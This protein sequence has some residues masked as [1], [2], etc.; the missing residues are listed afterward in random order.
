M[1]YKTRKSIKNSWSEYDKTIA[2]THLNNYGVIFLDT[3]YNLPIDDLFELEDLY[4]KYQ[5]E[6]QNLNH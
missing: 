1:N 6:S 4:E 2:T 5:K 3:K